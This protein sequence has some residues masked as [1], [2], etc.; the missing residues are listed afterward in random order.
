MHTR[1]AKTKARPKQWNAGK[2]GGVY[3]DPVHEEALRLQRN[4]RTVLQSAARSLDDLA[5][6]LRALA[7]LQ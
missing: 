5:A 4:R 1:K 3:L 7:D 6:A 2:P